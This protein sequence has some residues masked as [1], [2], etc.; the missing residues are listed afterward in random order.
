MVIQICVKMKDYK[1]G[2]LMNCPDAAVNIGLNPIWIAFISDSYFTIA[3]S[4][5]GNYPLTQAYVCN[6]NLCTTVEEQTNYAKIY[7]NIIE[8]YAYSYRCA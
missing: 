1:I 2:R 5:V 4:G 3:T 6:L 8:K 7:W